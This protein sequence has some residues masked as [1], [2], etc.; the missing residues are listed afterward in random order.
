MST[1][2]YHGW[3]FIHNGGLISFYCYTEELLQM[4]FYLINFSHL[5]SSSSHTKIHRLA[6]HFHRYRRRRRCRAKWMELGKFNL[7]WRNYEIFLSP[8]RLPF[9]TINSNEQIPF[10]I[11]CWINIIS[12]WFFTFHLLR[13]H[14][15]LRSPVLSSKL[16]FI[17][18]F[19]KERKKE[20]N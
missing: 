2:Y 14:L 1:F 8:L 7:R 17:I 20:I 6:C 12:K 16:S 18:I 5:F 15:P 4:N 11:Q 3:I 10:F 19:Q 9:H 13:S